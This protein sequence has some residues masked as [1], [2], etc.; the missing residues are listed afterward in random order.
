MGR[1]FLLGGL[2]FSVRMLWGLQL[3]LW[4]SL[5]FVV[6]RCR[7]QGFCLFGGLLFIFVYYVVIILLLAIFIDCGGYRCVRGVVD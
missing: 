4:V 7:L 2:L 5:Y 3:W 6:V 1:V